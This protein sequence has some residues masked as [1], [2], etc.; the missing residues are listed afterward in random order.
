MCYHRQWRR[1]A[2][3]PFLDKIT[4]YTGQEVIKE[5]QPVELYDAG[6][7]SDVLGVVQNGMQMV[8]TQGLASGVFGN[9]PV[10]IACK[11][12]TAETSPNPKEEA[13]KQT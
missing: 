10:S 13:R 11:T 6:I 7:S 4:D 2:A 5:Y 12:G 3:S 9:Y 8:A 1:A